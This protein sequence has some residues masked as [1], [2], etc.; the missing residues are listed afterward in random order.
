MAAEQTTLTIEEIDA[1]IDSSQSS[2]ALFI[3]HWEWFVIRD[4]GRHLSIRNN[5]G[6]RYRGLDVWISGEN[7]LATSYECDWLNEL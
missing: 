1:I 3:Q 5:G 4:A 2:R 7:R 6:L